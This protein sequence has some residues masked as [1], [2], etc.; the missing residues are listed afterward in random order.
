MFGS[1]NSLAVG[2]QVDDLLL[3][4]AEA[5]GDV[6]P[7]ACGQQ[8]GTEVAGGGRPGRGQDGGLG[9]REGGGERMPGIPSVGGDHQGIVPVQAQ[10]GEGERH[11]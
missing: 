7:L 4:G 5:F 1:A 10:P 2:G 6:H 8:F 3:G 11:R 9:V